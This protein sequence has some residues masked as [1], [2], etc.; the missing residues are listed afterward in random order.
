MKPGVPE[1]VTIGNPFVYP[2]GNGVGL[3]PDVNTW[4]GPVADEAQALFNTC[5]QLLNGPDAPTLTIRELP[6]ELII[7]LANLP[8]SNNVG[9]KYS[10]VDGATEA[11]VDRYLGGHGDSTYKFQGYLLYQLAGPTVS[12]TD[13]NN[14][15]QAV[16][17]GQSDIKDSVSTIINYITDPTL[18]I[19]P[20]LEVKGS[21]TG[22][23]LFV[24]M[25]VP[26][27]LHRAAII[28]WLTM[29]LYYF[30]A[31][32]YAYNDYIQYNPNNP[33]AGGQL[34]HSCKVETTLRFMRPHHI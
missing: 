2:P 13:L 30:A 24:T 33:T 21:N 10:Q 16:L 1:Y 28:S 8:G 20:T 19:V 32:A 23:F 6:N 26:T 9:E 25:L 29:P 22:H 31:V 3:C 27:L 34:L 18:G 11:A 12:A 14:P 4:I 7:N 5:F 15:S 17:I